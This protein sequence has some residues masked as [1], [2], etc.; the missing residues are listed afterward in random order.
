MGELYGW[1]QFGG[2]APWRTF[3]AIAPW[4]D[5]NGFHV[6]S[7]MP[8]TTFPAPVPRWDHALARRD[9]AMSGSCRLTYLQPEFATDH[10]ALL[11]VVPLY[12]EREEQPSPSLDGLRRPRLAQLR[13]P[14]RVNALREAYRATADSVSGAL[15]VAERS[16]AERQHTLASVQDIV[17]FADDVLH[18]MVM[19][20]S[21]EVLGSYDAVRVRALPDREMGRLVEEATHSSTSAQRLWKKVKRGRVRRMVASEEAA[22]AGRSAAEEAREYWG[23]QWRS[24]G[25]QAPAPSRL[26]VDEPHWIDVWSPSLAKEFSAE[27]VSRALNRY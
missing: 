12:P 20:C 25:K 7:P 1:G 15:D 22:A 14:Q 24:F 9:L 21:L 16:A 4:L 3:D 5:K 19:E 17:D 2:V 26:G 11:L 13:D 10:L 18:R 23:E 8:T 6:I 27:E